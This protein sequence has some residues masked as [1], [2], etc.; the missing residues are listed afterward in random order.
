MAENFVQVRFESKKANGALGMVL[1]NTRKIKPSY[2]RENEFTNKF[3][4]SIYIFSK[5]EEFEQFD[6][7]DGKVL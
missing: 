2:L 6:M 7:T 4:N 1:H 3:S 5:D